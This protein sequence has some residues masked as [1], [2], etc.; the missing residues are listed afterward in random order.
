[1]TE[2]GLQLV[3]IWL[4]IIDIALAVLMRHPQWFG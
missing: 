4:C 1:M 3:V 2:L